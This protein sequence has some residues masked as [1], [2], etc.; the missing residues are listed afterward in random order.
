MDAWNHYSP[1]VSDSG[2]NP[3][4]HFYDNLHKQDK[5]RYT[6]YLSE[7]MTTNQMRTSLFARL[8]SAKSK[9]RI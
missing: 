9:I 6:L 1:L 4:G 3:N 7:F 8:S 2:W 5:Q